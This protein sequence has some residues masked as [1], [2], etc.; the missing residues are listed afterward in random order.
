MAGLPCAPTQ[1]AD[2]A[3]CF[4]YTLG[5]RS[6][7]DPRAADGAAGGGLPGLEARLVRTFGFHNTGYA[8]SRLRRGPSVIEPL[9]SPLYGESL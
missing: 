5:S 4:G 1:L 9:R 7:R 2:G 6:P 3:G 8:F